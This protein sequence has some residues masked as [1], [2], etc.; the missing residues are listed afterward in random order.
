MMF[1]HKVG[2]FFKYRNQRTKYTIAGLVENLNAMF[3]L[4]VFAFLILFPSV[5]SIAQDNLPEEGLGVS[6]AAN[7]TFSGIGFIL[8]AE[9][10]HR[11]HIFY[12]GPKLQLSR[13][14]LPVNG[15]FGWNLGYRH[16]YNKS[17]ERFTS[18][19]FN[20]DYQIGFS[21]A[22]SRYQTTNKLNYVHEAFIGYG[23]QFRLHPRLYLANVLGVGTH[24][25]SYYN[26]DLKNR[27]TYT[28]YNHLFKFFLNYKF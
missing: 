5:L 1:L 10:Q 6:L 17:P 22:Y 15:P 27:I 7:Y 19:F 26:A 28:G 25:E 2:S 13:T 9:W 3:H 12:T 16:D 24:F 14:Y 4:F 21:K 18:F 23:V 20:L 8:D 11:N